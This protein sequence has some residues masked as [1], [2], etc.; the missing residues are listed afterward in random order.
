MS[1]GNGPVA[2][3]RLY[4]DEDGHSR[5]EDVRLG[6]E[7]R[8]VE[9]SELRAAFSEPFEAQYAM[10]RHVVSEASADH[11]HNAPR[12]QFIIQLTGRC[13]IETSDGDRRRLGPGSVLLVEDVDG[14]GHITR[15]LGDEDRLTM[16]IPL[17]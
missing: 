9:E 17:R 16:I 6:G 4:A 2:Y 1:S 8:G 12:R 10:F 15:R 3:V 7:P 5:F 11:P 13:E 14:L